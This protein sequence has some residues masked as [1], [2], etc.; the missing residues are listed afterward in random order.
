MREQLARRADAVLW[1]EPGTHT[2]S[3]K[4]VAM[5]ERLA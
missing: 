3:G 1:V 4:L 5:R 2:D